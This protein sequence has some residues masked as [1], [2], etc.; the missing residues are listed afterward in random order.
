MAFSS[1]GL[2]SPHH[3]PPSL[4]PGPRCRHPHPSSPIAIRDG[5]GGGASWEAAGRIFCLLM[6][7]CKAYKSNESLFYNRI[8]NVLADEQYLYFL[9]L[10]VGPVIR[11][12]GGGRK[13]RRV[14]SIWQLGW[15]SS[16]EANSLV[17]ELMFKLMTT[18]LLIPLS[19]LVLHPLLVLYWC[20]I[21]PATRLSQQDYGQ[22]DGDSSKANLKPAMMIFYSLAL[23]Q[24][25]L[26]MLWFILNAG[27]A[28]MVRVVASKCDFEKS[29]G[30]KSVDQYLSD[31]KFKCLK[32]PSSIKDMNLIKFAAG[33]LDSDSEDDYI[34]GARM[35][36]SFI[37]KQKLPVKLLIRSSRI[38]TQKLITM[39]GWTDPADRE[40]R[41]LAA[42]IVGHVASNINLSQFPGALQSIGSLL[43]PRDDLSFYDQD[44]QHDHDKGMGRCQLLVQGLL[45][46]E[47]LTCDHNNCI[48]ICRDHCLLSHIRYA[49]RLRKKVT[50]PDMCP[51]WPKMLKGLLR[52]MA[53]LI[54]GVTEVELETLE[55]I[56]NELPLG[57]IM[58]HKRF[59]DI[60]I[61]TIALYANLLYYRDTTFPSE[62]F[63]ETMLP[64]FLSCTDIEQ[65]E[66]IT[67]V[68]TKVGVLAGASLAKLLLKSEDSVIRDDIMKGEQEASTNLVAELFLTNSQMGTQA[69]SGALAITVEAEHDGVKQFLGDNAQ[70]SS[71]NRLEHE[72]QS[73]YTE[74]QTTLLHVLAS[75]TEHGTD[76]LANVIQKIAPG[77]GLSRFVGMLKSLVEK[78]SRVVT[79][80]GLIIIKATAW[81][82]MWMLR[83]SEFVQEIRQQKIVEALSEATKIVSR[84]SL[85]KKKQP[86]SDLD[87]WKL[88]GYNIY[89]KRFASNIRLSS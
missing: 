17:K 72:E 66:E 57:M 8:F 12:F 6:F 25:T 23:A 9:N 42:I 89:Y 76:C 68:W 22:G 43:D 26:Y 38:R 10:L 67:S 19:L 24:G 7:P 2:R 1:P 65:G 15:K 33:L 5:L 73:N 60:M 29:W 85:T 75:T 46:I 50:F 69:Q 21:V 54:A 64:V 20:I 78:H 52:A 74:L 56:F 27:N 84:T 77:D 44:D 63:V 81:L 18:V 14:I 35:L 45:V 47:R 31:T 83:R 16:G 61:P 55:S 51:V 59:P 37:Q 36:V 11:A 71:L 58:G 28:M 41:M 49:I 79:E 82:I 32:D 87:I 62:H 70:T 86:A 4:V 39:L 34:T 13:N 53:Y 88:L 48:L 80:D 3:R 30:R 40:I